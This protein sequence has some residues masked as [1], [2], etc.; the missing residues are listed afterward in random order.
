MRSDEHC[1]F[2]FK[3]REDAAPACSYG[4]GHEFP[5]GEE[6]RVRQEKRP[7]AKL[8][9]RCGLHPRNPLSSTNGCEHAYP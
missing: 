5:K 1:V 9:V 3:H 8:C 7:D 2:C 6:A 4:L